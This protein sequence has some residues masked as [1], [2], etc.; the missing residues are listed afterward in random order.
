MGENFKGNSCKV[1]HKKE[2][3]ESLNPR[4]LGPFLKIF[5]ILLV[6]FFWNSSVAFPSQIDPAMQW[7]LLYIKIRDGSILQRRGPT[8]V[9]ILGEFA[10]RFLSQKL[11]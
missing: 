9:K 2:A 7:H 4:I 1:K 8:P 5:L 11:G 3:L 6:L 10:E